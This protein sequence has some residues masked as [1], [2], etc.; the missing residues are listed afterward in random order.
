MTG[1]A[2]VAAAVAGLAAAFGV[3]VLA[4]AAVPQIHDCAGPACPGHPAATPGGPAR[5]GGAGAPPG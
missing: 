5:A 2:R 1:P 4:G 3:A